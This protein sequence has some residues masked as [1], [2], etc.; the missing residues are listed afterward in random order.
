DK[1]AKEPHIFTHPIDMRRGP[2]PFDDL[3]ALWLWVRLLRRVRPDV[4]SVGTP[5]AGLLGAVS[6]K[7][8]GVKHRVY[9]LRGLR[10][11]TSTGVRRAILAIVE[12]LTMRA[13]TRV[14][15]I[16]PSL[17]DRAVELELLPREKVSVLHHGSS[18][19]IDTSEFNPRR[20][21]AVETDLLRREVGIPPVVPVVGFVGRLTRDKGL[22]V[23][24]EAL[25]LLA[26][27]SIPFH[28]LIVGGVDD[29]TGDAAIERLKRNGIPVSITG[30]VSE[31]AHYY[32]LMRLLCLPSFREGFGNVIIEASSMEIPVV[33][34][35]A[36]GVVDAVNDCKTGLL[37]AVGD[38]EQ[39]ADNLAR[40]LTDAECANRMGRAGRAWVLDRFERQDVQ[41]SYADDLEALITE[42]S[43]RADP[44]AGLSAR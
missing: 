30:H 38:A 16:S 36:T 14:L 3:R 15:A 31:P 11:E 29:V 41:R 39:L 28:A 13:A 27:R 24:A 42:G 6:A 32:A 19:G 2:S 43:G 23:L 34:T 40:L 10:L 35:A 8:V 5:K 17:A 25:E 12:R 4:V 22:F 7:L 37:S 20:F 21:R 18:N 9:L 44:Q 33:A 26:D 1:L